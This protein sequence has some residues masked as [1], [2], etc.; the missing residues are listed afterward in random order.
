MKE[1]IRVGITVWLL[2]NC[3]CR[4][5]HYNIAHRNINQIVKRKKIIGSFRVLF[6]AGSRSMEVLGSASC[7]LQSEAYMDSVKADLDRYLEK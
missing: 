7:D 2:S 6:A 5:L 4:K 3:I 1:V